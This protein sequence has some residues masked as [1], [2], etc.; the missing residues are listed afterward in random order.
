MV[1]TAAQLLSHGGPYHP[2]LILQVIQEIRQDSTGVL[3]TTRVW[4]VES[5]GVPSFE[6]H[7]R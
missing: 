6:K 7:V 1:L 2:I 4:K 3:G 5:F